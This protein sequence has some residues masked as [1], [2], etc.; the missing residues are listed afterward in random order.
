MK[1]KIFRRLVRIEIKKS[2]DSLKGQE[3]NVGMPYRKAIESRV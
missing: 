2:R 3:K 1:V